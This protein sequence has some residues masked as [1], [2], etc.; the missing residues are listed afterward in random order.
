[1]VGLMPTFF[2]ESNMREAS[3]LPDWADALKEMGSYGVLEP[4]TTVNSMTT[5]DFAPSTPAAY[6][7]GV[8]GAGLP[9]ATESRGVGA[10]GAR[11]KVR[12]PRR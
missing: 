7:D 11:V 12:A 10:F 4:L 9:T 5:K 2:S 3:V 1:M 6:C 8:N